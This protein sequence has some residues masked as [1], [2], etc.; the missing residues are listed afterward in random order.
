MP[1][2]CMH[3]HL[4]TGKSSIIVT[5]ESARAKVGAFKVHDQSDLCNYDLNFDVRMVTLLFVQLSL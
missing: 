1:V 3:V 2:Q 5:V 4:L